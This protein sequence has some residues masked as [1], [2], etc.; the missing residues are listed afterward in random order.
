MDE[1]EFRMPVGAKVLVTGATGFTGAVLV[2][3]LA[4]Q[5]CVV[6]A[7]A[8]HSANVGVLKDLG[9]EWF[10]G[11]VYDAAVV[12]AAVAGVNYIFHAAAA[13]RV[14]GLPDEEYRRVHETSTQ[15]LAK[16]ALDQPDFQRFVHVS[17]VGVHGHVE[18]PPANEE[19]PF[20]PGDIY[21]QTKAE[22]ELWLHAF[23]REKPLPYSVIRPAA[24][25][26]PGDRRLLK[27]FK[28]ALKPVFILLGYSKGLYHLIHVEDLVSGMIL[29]AVHPA[30]RGEAFICGNPAAVT[31]EHM[32]RVVAAALGKKCRVLRLPAWPVFLAADLCE[33]ICKPLKI[34]PPLYRRRV[35][36]FTKD[37]SFDTR[38]I[39]ER[40]GF[41]PRYTDDEGLAQTARWYREHHWL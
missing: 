22:A 10:R 17:T 24:I 23:A 35:A 2:R 40:L 21:Q 16:A 7:I 3:R 38:K 1:Q 28:L 5:G 18:N 20:H 34:A 6:R 14:S 19:T 8:R 32:G 13:Y 37:R 27:I 9:I 25:Y 26:G 15:L 11:D 4:E 39:R 36:F 30:A 12:Q 41:C 33:M 29:A 31:Q